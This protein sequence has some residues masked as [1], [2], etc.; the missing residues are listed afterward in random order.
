[1]GWR[2]REG[3]TGLA[4]GLTLV[5]AIKR[6]QQLGREQHE[7]TGF[8]VTVELVILEKSLML[9]QHPRLSMEATA[10]V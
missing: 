5:K 2:V 3:A 6:A 8:P 1:V 7:R 10:T 4:E 9:A